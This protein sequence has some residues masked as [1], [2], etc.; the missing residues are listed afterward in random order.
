MILFY[1]TEG[2][3]VVAALPGGIHRIVA[4]DLSM[5]PEQPSVE[6]VQDILDTQGFGPGQ[7]GCHQ[8]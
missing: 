1:A 8:T 7:H 3:N 6:F 5:R 4:P 2:L